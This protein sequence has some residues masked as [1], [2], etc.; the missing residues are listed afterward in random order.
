MSVGGR[1]TDARISS[2]FGLSCLMW[3][4]TT[5]TKP[6]AA[7]AWPKPRYQ[8]F[9]TFRA[10]LIDVGV[11][12]IVKTRKGGKGGGGG[13]DG[14]WVIGLKYAAYLSQQLEDDMIRSWR[15]LKKKR[16]VQFS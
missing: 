1:S 5:F 15:Q 12:H 10:K 11:N 13:T 7:G 8:D 2:P 9:I 3:A 16:G 4:W 14:Y 6:S